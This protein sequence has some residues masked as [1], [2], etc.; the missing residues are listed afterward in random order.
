MNRSLRDKLPTLPEKHSP[1]F[2]KA[3]INDRE[4]KTKAKNYFDKRYKAK[5]S[6]IQQGDHV[7]LRQAKENK[8]STKYKAS[9]L[10]VIDRKGTLL[11]VERNG[12]TIAV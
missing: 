1:T 11:Q 8:L 6:D 5:S 3:Q 10:L 9:P 12:R 2:K 7:L 4:H